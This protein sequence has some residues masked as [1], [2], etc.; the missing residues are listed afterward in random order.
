MKY[1][2]CPHLDTIII[3]GSG[4]WMYWCG[5]FPYKTKKCVAEGYKYDYTECS[6][7]LFPKDRKMG[8]NEE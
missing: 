2:R 7:Y 4:E 5:L 8:V 3:I 1:E 6:Y